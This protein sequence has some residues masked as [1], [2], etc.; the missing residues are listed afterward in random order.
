MTFSTTDELPHLNDQTYIALMQGYAA[1]ITKNSSRVLR[2][3]SRGFIGCK[4]SALSYLLISMVWID[5]SL[6]TIEDKLGLLSKINFIEN[7]SVFV[8]MEKA[9][10][11]HKKFNSPYLSR[12]F[13]EN[14]RSLYNVS[15]QIKK[16]KQIIFEDGVAFMGI[17]LPATKYDEE[18]IVHYFI[19]IKRN[20]KEPYKIISSYGSEHVS[21]FQYESTLYERS[22]IDFVKSLKKIRKYKPDNT[23]IFSYMRCHFM[24]D[25]FIN[26]NEKEVT[27]N[28][29]AEIKKYQDKPHIVVQFNGI[30]SDLRPELNSRRGSPFSMEHEVGP[31]GMEHEVGSPDMENEEVPPGIVNEEGGPNGCDGHY[32]SVEGASF[33]ASYVATSVGVDAPT[34]NVSASSNAAAMSTE[35]GSRKSKR[36]KSKRKKYKKIN[37]TLKY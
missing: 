13:L 3:Q 35:G 6:P 7:V 34:A 9:K 18:V 32:E 8:R 14:R 21:Y 27:G 15:T 5:D 23:R 36:K 10:Q 26:P 24:N 25:A 33:I 11:K 12:L 1:I 30:F 20:E 31:P 37:Y 4:F 19:I 22:F 16:F 17:I 29:T 28:I 2:G